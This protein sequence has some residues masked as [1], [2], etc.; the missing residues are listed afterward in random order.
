MYSEYPNQQKEVSIYPVGRFSDVYL[1]KPQGKKEIEGGG[2]FYVYDEV[3][4]RLEDK[5][6]EEYVLKNFDTLFESANKKEI[7]IEEKVIEH[8]SK[9]VTL[10]EVIDALFGGV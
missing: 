1:R 10:E 4:L 9:I 6:S 3:Q 2:I 5:V 7:S 8:D